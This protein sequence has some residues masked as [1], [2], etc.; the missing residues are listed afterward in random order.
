MASAT[1]IR[2]SPFAFAQ[3][4][5]IDFPTAIA[6]FGIARITVCPL[7][8]TPSIF[9][10]ANPVIVEI[11]ICRSVNKEAHS[12]NTSSKAAGCNAKITMSALCTALWLSEVSTTFL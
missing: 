6:V 5:V 10:I 12:L 8:I 4:Q 7:P 2:F 11:K 9:E 1:G 3:R